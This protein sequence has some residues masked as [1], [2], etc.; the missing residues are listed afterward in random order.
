MTRD[1]KAQPLDAQMDEMRHDSV[2]QRAYTLW[3]AAGR[4]EGSAL[5]YWLQAERE[6]GIPSP[7]EERDLAMVLEDLGL[8]HAAGRSDEP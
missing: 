4:P 7:E 8:S 5:Q 6:L 2:E 1:P 3:E